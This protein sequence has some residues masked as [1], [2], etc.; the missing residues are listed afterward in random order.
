MDG[1]LDAECAE[2]AVEG[3]HGLFEGGQ[4]EVV[5]YEEP[6]FGGEEGDWWLWGFGGDRHC[7]GRGGDLDEG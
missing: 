5:D 3:A 7:F 2:E 6:E 1:G 4:V